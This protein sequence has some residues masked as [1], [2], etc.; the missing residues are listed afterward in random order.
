LIQD[1][2]GSFSLIPIRNRKRKRISGYYRKC[3]A[4]SFDEEK[5]HPGNKVET[6]FPVLK[7]KFGEAL[8]SRKY[9]LQVK[10]IKIKIIHYNISKIIST[11]S[12]LILF[13]EF[14][15]VQIPWF[16]ETVSGVLSV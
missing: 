15:R 8:K 14:Y 3:I 9:R 6:V 12:F 16:Y 11:S 4:Q 13:E 1:T 7:R 2:L 5:C 10:E